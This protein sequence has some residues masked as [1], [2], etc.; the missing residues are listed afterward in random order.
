MIRVRI[1]KGNGPMPLPG[2]GGLKLSGKVVGS[3]HAGEVWDLPD[4][5]LRTAMNF[6][7]V[8]HVASGQVHSKATQVKHVHP[9]VQAGHHVPAALVLFGRLFPGLAMPQWH[10]VS[11]DEEP[12]VADE[13]EVAESND[14][15][16]EDVKHE[17]QEKDAKASPVSPV[18]RQARLKPDRS[19]PIRK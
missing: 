19:A 6:G 12:E 17:E 11:P 3:A 13:P 5:M 2:L 16:G 1:D 18:D 14:E 9:H 8:V 4:S 15:E 10:G 7:T